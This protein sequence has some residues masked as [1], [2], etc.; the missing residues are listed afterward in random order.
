MPLIYNAQTR[1]SVSMSDDHGKI[2]NR[3][4]SSYV[5]EVQDLILSQALRMF[6]LQL[7]MC[8]CSQLPVLRSL[9]GNA[10]GLL[11]AGDTAQ[12]VSAGSHFKFSE[13]KAL[14]YRAEVGRFMD[15]LRQS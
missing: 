2:D 12:S 14:M 7:V 6:F 10:S 1:L 3:A 15:D 5:D 13:L 11:W 8:V 9:C 4:Y